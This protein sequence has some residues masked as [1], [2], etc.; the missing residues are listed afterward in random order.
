MISKR[1]TVYSLTPMG[2]G[3]KVSGSRIRYYIHLPVTAVFF[4]QVHGKG[5]LVYTYG[6][7][8]V[9]EWM[10]AKKHGEGELIYSNGDK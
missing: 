4:P 6:D 9:G 10:D 5:T 3:T 2:S 7:K 1:V 8:Y